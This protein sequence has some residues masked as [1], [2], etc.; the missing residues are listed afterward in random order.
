MDFLKNNLLGLVAIVIATAVLFGF[1]FSGNKTLLGSTNC[2]N[3]TCLTGGLAI[4]TGNFS[5]DVGTAAVNATTTLSDTLVLD[6]PGICINFYAT[7]TATRG[8]LIA[9]TTGSTITGAD[10]VMTFGYG[11]CAL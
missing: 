11:A 3:T 5:V 9:S 4:T 6:N 7:S 2:Q 10:G 1:H 8:H